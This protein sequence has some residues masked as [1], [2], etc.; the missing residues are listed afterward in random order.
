LRAAPQHEAIFIYLKNLKLHPEEL[1]VAK[2]LEG[3][4][5]A[6]ATAAQKSPLKGEGPAATGVSLSNNL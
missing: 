4:L 6:I 2:R 1:C 5:T 3:S